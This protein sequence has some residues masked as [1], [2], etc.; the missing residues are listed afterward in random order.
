MG[1]ICRRLRIALESEERT[2]RQAAE[3]QQGH[4]RQ[5]QASHPR[6]SVVLFDLSVSICDTW[7]ET[8]LLD[9]V[10]D[11]SVSSG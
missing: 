11:W 2:D 5:G 3:G 10:H 4:Q 1:K 7:P 6:P 8:F 9:P